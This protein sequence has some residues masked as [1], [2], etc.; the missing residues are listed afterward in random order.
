MFTPIR[1]LKISNF[2]DDEE[3]KWLLNYVFQQKSNFTKSEL[4]PP[5]PNKRKSTVLHSWDKEWFICKLQLLAT[6]AANI[7]KLPEPKGG[8]VAQITASN[9][10]DFLSPHPDKT[11][12]TNHLLTF[13]Y[14]FHQIPKSFIGGSLVI[15]ALDNQC[16]F[17]VVEPVDNTLILFNSR[18]W[19]EVLTV[20]CPS[21]DFM[22]S[23]FTVNGWFNA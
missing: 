2:L 3:R 7:L 9:N 12:L 19:H 17:E 16:Q 23:R 6:P 5:D 21:Q 13:V 4:I 8:I 10:N 15:Y 11:E 14:Y 20:R 18:F 1:Y 22:H